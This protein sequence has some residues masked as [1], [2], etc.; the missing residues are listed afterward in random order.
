MPR[1]RE[2]KNGRQGE[3]DRASYR[4]P[5]R[6]LSAGRYEVEREWRRL[7]GTPQ[8]DLLRTL[9]ERFLRRSFPTPLPEGRWAVEVGPGPGRFTP[10]LAETSAQLLL[11]DLSR[12][13]LR[14]AAVRRERGL[15]SRGRRATL[16]LVLGDATAWPVRPGTIERLTAIGNVVGFSGDRAEGILREL[17]ASLA[18]GGEIVVESVCPTTTLPKFAA[19]WRRDTRAPVLAGDPELRLRPLLGQGWE[20]HHVPGG[21]HPSSA[22][23]HFFHPREIREA[24]ARLGIEVREQEV[25]APLSGDNPELVGR[26]ARGGPRG[27]DELVRWEEAAGHRP[28]FLE[29]GGHA[30]TLA[31]RPR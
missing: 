29:A 10:V 27:L 24:L 4:G 3:G 20:R 6:F 16:A 14:A 26:I 1:G 8:R 19:R 22:E 28:E 25:L 30:L 12:E 11:V 9:R 31:V 7:E 2:R 5:R 15:G 21:P 13:M 17:S 18:P 23:F